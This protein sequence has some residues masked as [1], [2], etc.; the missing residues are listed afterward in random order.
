[1]SSAAGSLLPRV[2]TTSLR[3]VG[4][5]RFLWLVAA[6]VVVVAAVA[7]PA[8]RNPVSVGS[9]LASL[10]PIL[11]IAVGQAVVV[12]Y[13]GIDLSVGATA[14]L[15]TVLVALS[16]VLPGGAPLALALVLAGGLVVGLLN[17]AGVVA[18]INPLLMT[19]A[20]SGVVQ[21]V[22][23][24]LQGTEGAR[25]P[26]AVFDVLGASVG[27]VPLLAV[28]ALVVLVATW[29]WVGQTRTGRVVQAAGYDRRT[30]TRLGF[31]VRRTTFVVYAVSGLLS[32]VGGL[33]IVVRTYTADALVGSSAVIDSIA[34]VLVAGIVITGGIGS[35]LSVLPAALIIAVVGQV[36]TLTGTDSYYQTIFK[37]VLLVAAVGVYSLAGKKITVPWRLRQPAVARPADER[38]AS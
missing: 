19:F 36:I 26:G 18:G 12:M 17:A 15:A 7:L 16:P 31:P 24:L 8:F 27:P 5:A 3:S 33:A 20:M 28:V 21:G 10:T 9:L 14:G 29:L 11:L 2:S 22:A 32:S 4:S 34:T 38:S 25:I 1:M 13:G 37:G 30:A 6:L 35:V 23:L